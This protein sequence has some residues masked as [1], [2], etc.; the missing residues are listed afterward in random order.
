MRSERWEAE[1][2]FFRT[3]FRI[4]PPFAISSWLCPASGAST[5]NVPS[6]LFGPSGTPPGL[7]SA[8][9]TLSARLN[10]LRILSNDSSPSFSNC[11]IWRPAK[12]SVAHSSTC[13]RSNW[14]MGDEESVWLLIVPQLGQLVSAW[15]GCVTICLRRFDDFLPICLQDL[16]AC[17]DQTPTISQ[18]TESSY[19]PQGHGTSCDRCFA[20]PRH[21]DFKPDG[22]AMAKLYMLR[23][24]DLHKHQVESGTRIW[25]SMLNFGHSATFDAEKSL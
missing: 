15:R 14:S 22:I 5:A 12:R 7:S 8:L 4:G 2:G 17:R 13:D 6:T 16:A 21:Q 25:N 1:T 19:L 3:L 24:R 9:R 10:T 23:K 20:V 18:R 11:N